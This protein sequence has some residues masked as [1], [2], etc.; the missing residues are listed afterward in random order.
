MRQFADVAALRG[1]L[2][3][4]RVAGERVALVP[5]MGNIHEGHLRLVDAARAHGAQRVVVSVFVN[6][7]QFDRADDFARYP[8]TLAQDAQA[9]HGRGADA[10]FAPAVEQMYPGGSIWRRSSSPRTVPDRW[11]ASSGRATS[12]A[13]PRW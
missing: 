13:W 12:A 4:W 11:R 6:P 9:L 3:G 10:L 1:A 2:K 8:R 5:T 7:T